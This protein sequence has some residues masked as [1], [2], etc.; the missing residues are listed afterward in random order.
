MMS[1]LFVPLLLVAFLVGLIGIS[2][3]PISLWR[4]DTCPTVY[5]AL[6]LL[7][8][9]PAVVGSYFSSFHFQYYLNPNTQVAGW[10]IPL[11]I[12]QRD[13]PNGPWIDYVGWVTDF[14][15]PMNC[16]ILLGVSLIIVWI[17][18]VLLKRSVRMPA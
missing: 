11:A 15:F 8:I 1:A 9:I 2:Y 3:C 10:P 16:V 12:F 18:R 5:K 17:I 14:A 13:T 4:D 6:S 7:L